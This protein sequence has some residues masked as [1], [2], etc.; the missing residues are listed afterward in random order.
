MLANP[1]NISGSTTVR[2]VVSAPDAAT[3]VYHGTASGR[4]ELSSGECPWQNWWECAHPE[5]I[6]NRSKPDC[7]SLQK[8]RMAR[9]TDMAWSAPFTLSPNHAAHCGS[10]GEMCVD[11][12]VLVDRSVVEI[13]V[14]GGRVAALMA[15]EPPDTAHTFVHLFAGGQPQS[16]ST[17]TTVTLQTVNVWSVGCG[18]NESHRGVGVT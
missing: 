4:I 8:A 17:T 16:V 1:D 10:K 18:W 7:P 2:V 13:F 6:G 15:Y 14:A 9:P 12:R 5:C 11:V 3:G